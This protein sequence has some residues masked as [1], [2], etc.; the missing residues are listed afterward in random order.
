MKGNASYHDRVPFW[1]VAVRTDDRDTVFGV[2]DDVFGVLDNLLK[3]NLGFPFAERKPK[4]RERWD[5][6]KW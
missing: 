3:Q 6:E 2:Q 4:R 5:D 1:P